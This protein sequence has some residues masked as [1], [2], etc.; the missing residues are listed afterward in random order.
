[1][2]KEKKA[3]YSYTG[4]M[5]CFFQARNGKTVTDLCSRACNTFK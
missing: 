5:Q 1:M 2:E 4:I 3:I